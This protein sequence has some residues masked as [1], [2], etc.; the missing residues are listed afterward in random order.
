[1]GRKARNTTTQKSGEVPETMAEKA[2]IDDKMSDPRQK[3]AFAELLLL[4][5]TPEDKQWVIDLVRS[6]SRQFYREAMQK[7]G[8]EE[9]QRIERDRDHHK[10]QN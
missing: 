8:P 4:Y 9:I 3:A 7:K 6:Y 2:W 1:M 10:G 5:D